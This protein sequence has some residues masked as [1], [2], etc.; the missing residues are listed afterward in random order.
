[1]ATKGDAFCINILQVPIASG[2]FKNT[3]ERFYCLLR[4]YLHFVKKYHGKRYRSR[5]RGREMVVKDMLSTCLWLDL[6]MQNYLLNLFIILHIKSLIIEKNLLESVHQ[7]LAL[8]LSNNYAST[9]VCSLTNYFVAGFI[10]IH[11]A[12]VHN[13]AKWTGWFSFYLLIM[14]DTFYDHY[15]FEFY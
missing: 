13:Y 2:I 15:N 6:K 12:P 7:M 5:G 3:S 14:Q 4:F 11:T 10:W 9:L 1:M 8:E